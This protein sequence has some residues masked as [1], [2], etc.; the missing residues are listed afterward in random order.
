MPEHREE[1]EPDTVRAMPAEMQAYVKEKPKMKQLVNLVMVSGLLVMP[2]MM[3]S[4][5]SSKDATEPETSSGANSSA[6]PQDHSQHTD[7]QKHQ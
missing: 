2:V 6:M 7:H 4:G 1:F 3:A 5:C